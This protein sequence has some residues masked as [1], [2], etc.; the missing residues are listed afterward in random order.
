MSFVPSHLPRAKIEIFKISL[1]G[2]QSNYFAIHLLYETQPYLS[3]KTLDKTCWNKSWK[4]WK[5]RNWLKFW[6]SKF[7]TLPTYINA[8]SGQV[9][10]SKPQKFVNKI[11]LRVEVF[12]HWKIDFLSCLTSFVEDGRLLIFFEKTTPNCWLVL[13]CMLVYCIL[14]IQSIA[15][16]K[17]I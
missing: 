2:H 1:I 8:E 16:M 9:L 5:L 10:L 15:V 6:N 3:V 12:F 13:K 4:S 14:Y 17:V 11:N 7:S